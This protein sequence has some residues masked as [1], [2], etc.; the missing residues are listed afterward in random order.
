VSVTYQQTAPS[1]AALADSILDVFVYAPLG[2]AVQMKEQ[3]PLLAQHGREAAAAG[4]PMYRTV[5]E[6]A[7][8]GFREKAEQHAGGITDLLSSLGIFGSMNSSSPSEHAEQDDS[9]VH[10]A[11][12]GT[13]A[14]AL[15]SDEAPAAEGPPIEGYDAMPAVEVV[16]MLLSLT[17]DERA[18]VAAHE[19]ANRGRRTILGKLEQLAQRDAT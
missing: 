16:K 15:S 13:A 7:V 6:F 3:L 1:F 5:G 10:D 8:K 12:P 9:D 19:R 18:A 14:A 2:V 4:L 17:I 11:P